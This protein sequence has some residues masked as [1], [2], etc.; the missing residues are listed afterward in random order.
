MEEGFLDGLDIE[1]C[2]G[3]N[4][5]IGA[6]GTGKSSIV[7]LIRFCLGVKASTADSAKRTTEHALAVLRGGQVT[8]TLADG[9]ERIIVTRNAS[10]NEPV[11]SAPFTPPLIFSQTEI[12]TVGLHAAGRLRLIDSFLRN[13]PVLSRT[14]AEV[15]SV[16]ASITR[17]LEAHRKDIEDFE[18]RVAKL[19]LVEQQLAAL[20]ADERSIEQFSVQT[21]VRTKQLDEISGETSKLAVELNLVNQQLREVTD[22]RG[23]LLGALKRFHSVESDMTP[24]AHPLLQNIKLRRSSTIKHIEM[25]VFELGSVVDAAESAAKE[26]NSKKL[27]LDERAR[28][29]RRELEALRE[30]AGDIARKGKALREEKAQLESLSKLVRDRRYVA[31]TLQSRRNDALSELER[32]RATRFQQRSAI[33]TRLSKRLAPRIRVEMTRAAQLEQ[34]STVL[35]EALRGSGLKYNELSAVIVESIAPHELLGF[36]EDRDVEG[37][38]AQARITKDRASRAIASLRESDMAAIATVPL[39]DDVSL[40]LLDGPL[41][42]DI[43]QLSTG[44]RCTVILP[45]ILEHQENVLV[46][47]QPEDHIDNSFI[48]D[49][50]IKS[51]LARS[52]HAGQI[53]LTTHNANIPVLGNA[54]RVVHMESD[55]RRGFVVVAD[56]LLDKRVVSAISKVMEGGREAFERRASFYAAAM[57]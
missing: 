52:G 24:A 20:A 6:R 14:E 21:A 25:A 27:E 51:L 12:E 28:H 11:S 56:K 23:V 50:L 35:T 13:L 7:E 19:P 1:F 57:P 18:E 49:T 8:V 17:E 26:W 54:S 53:I 32:I 2:P 16:V 47:D 43:S 9:N 15:V 3:L 31:Q 36:V 10:H 55:G 4:A 44:Q 29:I 22:L 45:L 30:G 33:A 48:A 39:E 5:I 42:K 38:A 41:Y 46:V 34:Y 40:Q 37:F